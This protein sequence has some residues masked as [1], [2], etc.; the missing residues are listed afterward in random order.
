MT[1]GAIL[2]EQGISVNVSKAG[3]VFINK[4]DMTETKKT[5]DTTPISLLKHH[6]KMLDEKA[7][8]QINKAIISGVS[9]DYIMD[10]KVNPTFEFKNGVLTFI[11]APKKK[12][13]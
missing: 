12:V 2:K 9:P 7:K 4:K 3:N 10:S 6:Y 11:P 1:I 8:E 13:A 5:A